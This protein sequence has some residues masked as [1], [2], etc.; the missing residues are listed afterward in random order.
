MESTIAEK[1]SELIARALESPFV[2]DV[3][4]HREPVAVVFEPQD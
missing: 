4:L 1:L 3:H 2:V